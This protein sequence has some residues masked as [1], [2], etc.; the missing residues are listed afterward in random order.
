MTQTPHTLRLQ[1]L[2]RWLRALA[3][4]LG[5][6]YAAAG[7][8]R[9]SMNADG[10][11][12]L[13]Q[14]DA[15]FRGD[16][17]VALNAVWSPLYPWIQG[18]ARFVLDP[19]IRW[20]VRT[21][22]LVNFLIYATTLA[23]FEF[24]WRRLTESRAAGPTTTPAGR[25]GFPDA[26][27]MCLGYTLFVWS[28]LALIEVWAVTPDMLVAAAVYVACGLLVRIRD[29][30]ATRRTFVALGVALGL[31]YLAKAVLFPLALVVLAI[32]VLVAG[33]IRRG[34]LRTLPAVAAFAALAAPLLIALSV[35]QGRP[36]FGEVGKLTYLKHVHGVPFPHWVP[37]L[38]TDVGEPD[39]PVR[40][41][42]EDPTVYEF[43][44][45]IG[46]TYPL[47]YDPVYWYRGLNAKLDLGR[48]LG[49]LV[50]NVEVYVELFAG[51]Q[52]GVLALTLLL[53]WLARGPCRPRWELLGVALAGL[54]MYAQI[55]VAPRYIA[56]FLVLLW[57]GALAGVRLPD[58][59]AN[60]RILAACGT[61][62]TLS[63]T[64]DLGLTSWHNVRG[65][66]G[67]PRSADIDS[68]ALVAAGAPETPAIGATPRP[69]EVA[70][71]LLA[72]GL[73]RGDAIGFVGY[74]FDAYWARLARLRI[75]AEVVPAEAG[76]FF[77]AGPERRAQILR[78]FAA[79]GA[80]AVVVDGV[81]GETVIDGCDP[82]GRT[83]LRLCPVP[84]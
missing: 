75:V 49:A 79:A 1:R 67:I 65:L 37:G 16:F 62:L 33:G 3:L 54:G 24:L 29:G 61:L 57:A 30:H 11:S 58:S 81:P 9:E 64:L 77:G 4:A 43:A 56:A 2:R 69:S 7:A 52:G 21:V 76:R 38:V 51:R 6:L 40:R 10:I 22:H 26:A 36:T 39:H 73:E 41:L 12:Y 20:E 8:L 23:C 48:Q 55:L 17:A 80:K 63:L 19:E 46:G 78:A 13:D 74:S 66:V 27:W 71:V 82:V 5:A 14:G 60:R 72:Q 84:P 50:R 59:P 18:A 45:P 47:F 42:L 32:G 53:L 31:G 83:G 28:S 44:T 34:A 35:G 70:E 68:T 15:W 25:I